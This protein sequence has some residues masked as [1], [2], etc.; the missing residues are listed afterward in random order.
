M[1]L[2]SMKRKINKTGSKPELD[3]I[4][5]G[6]VSPKIFTKGSIIE[7]KVISLKPGEIL[8]DIGGRAEGVISGKE[9]KLKG[10][11][12]EKK[13]GDTVLV[14]VMK[15]E[16]EE[17][18]IE[19]SIRRTGTALRWHELE[20]IRKEEKVIEVKVIEANTGGV[21]VEIEEGLRGFVPSSQLKN[22]RIYTDSTF[23]KKEDASKAVQSKLAELIDQKLEVKVME[24]DKEKN[25]VIL[26]EKYI[27]SESDMAQ[28]NSTLSSLKI[29]DELDGKVTGIAPFGLFVNAGGLEGL[30]HLSEISWD[31]VTNP[32]DF[33]K[34]DDPVKVQVIGLTD[35]GKRVAYSIKRLLEDPW[36][37]IVQN[38]KIGQV[39]DGEIKSIAQYG[40]FV[41]IEDGL[42]GL[43]HISELSSKLVKDPTKVVK[44]G[45]KV[46]VKIISISNE[47]RHLGLSIKRVASDK[48]EDLSSAERETGESQMKDLDKL[49]GTDKN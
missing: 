1:R 38:Y 21:I 15:P 34:V 47:D 22:S 12:L 5:E 19:L 2:N 18:Q 42:N 35:N 39:V 23:S 9:L 8:V 3:S 24:I 20:Q 30:V 6:I 32:G 29:G 11:K 17:G 7:G 4:I 48:K 31:K 10:K 28:R 14:Y 33:Y 44:V 37:S 41:K 16:N 43:I 45:D 49:I 46:K 36:K 13:L 40:A 27:F 25:K 26:S